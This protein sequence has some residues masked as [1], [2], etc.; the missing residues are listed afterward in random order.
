MACSS[1]EILQIAL[2]EYM[3]LEPRTSYSVHLY[4]ITVTRTSNPAILKL[5]LGKLVVK[6]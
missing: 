1:I 6:K 2:P 5:I 3:A 4:I